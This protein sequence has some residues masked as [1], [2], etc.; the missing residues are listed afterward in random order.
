MTRFAW[1]LVDIF[2]MYVSLCPIAFHLGHRILQL[3][4]VELMSSSS[5]SEKPLSPIR[6][7]AVYGT[8]CSPDHI[9]SYIREAPL[10]TAAVRND[11]EL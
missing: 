7:H 11:T 10:H 1:V 9:A 5:H 4:H 3:W 2:L 6:P 8:A